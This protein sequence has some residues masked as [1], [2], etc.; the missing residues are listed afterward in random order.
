MFNP[1]FERERLRSSVC[2]LL[3]RVLYLWV[4]TYE[5]R[6]YSRHC[7][8]ISSWNYPIFGLFDLHH[9]ANKKIPQRIALFGSWHSRSLNISFFGVFLPIGGFTFLDGGTA[10][11]KSLI[12]G[13]VFCPLI[14]PFAIRGVCFCV[15]IDGTYVVKRDLF[16]E[17]RIDLAN[18]ET[19]IDDRKPFTKAFWITISTATNETIQFN[20]RR[21]EGDLASFLKDCKR[22]QNK[23]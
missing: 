10:G 12:T 3:P 5:T 13:M 2:I 9:M 6:N 22:I 18:P 11:T 20:S 14:L 1:E 16:S 23:K 8:F 4:V 17:T 15:F 19:F 7:A 21:I